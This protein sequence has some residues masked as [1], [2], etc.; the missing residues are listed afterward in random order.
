[1]QLHGL[2][3]GQAAKWLQERYL[4][5][6][7][8]NRLSVAKK[9][10]LPVAAAHEVNGEYSID[11][12]VYEWILRHSPL[13]ESGRTYLNGRKLSDKTLEEFHVGQIGDSRELCN[14]AL[15]EFGRERV[16]RAGLVSLLPHSDAARFVFLSN[17]LLFPFLV[18]GR[19]EYLQ[20][21][22]AG[23]AT[24]RPRWKNLN[25]LQPPVFNV[26][27]LSKSKNIFLC[28]GVTD[29]LSAHELGQAAVALL[30]GGAQLPSNFM[31]QL[32]GRTIRILP[33]NDS[34]G[35]RMGLSLGQSLAKYGVDPIVQSWPVGINDVNEYL[36]SVRQ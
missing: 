15:A 25:G 34:A 1:M 20:T 26:G 21:R 18:D 2:E 32:K 14:I 27:A 35:R 36:I 24:A 12:D 30:G 23:N 11:P 28:E 16:R 19:C 4:G 29:V 9:D 10:K 3:F 6:A 31:A 13:Q 7:R 22:A 17:Y 8:T 5:L 33:D